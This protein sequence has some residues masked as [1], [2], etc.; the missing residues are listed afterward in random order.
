MTL[1]ITT[2]VGLSL[3][4]AGCTSSNWR[5]TTRVNEIVGFTGGILASG[6]PLEWKVITSGVNSKNSTMYTLYGNDLA[7]QHARTSD[8]PY[9]NNAVLALVTWRQQE[10]IRWFGAN[11]PSQPDSV[12]FLSVKL[13]EEGRSVDDYRLYKGAPLKEV[14]I[15]E[16]QTGTSIAHL[17]SLRAAVMP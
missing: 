4:L 7:V 6:N 14:T 5:V 12:E 3:V 2:L 15:P 17:R 10:D 9:P 16:S 8:A 11:V 1:V 13:S